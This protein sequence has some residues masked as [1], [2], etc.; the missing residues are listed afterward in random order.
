MMVASLLVAGAHFLFNY[1][2]AAIACEKGFAGLDIGG[3]GIVPLV[4]GCATAI[5]LIAVFA[6]LVG[7]LRRMGWRAPS[8]SDAAPAPVFLAWMTAAF[9]A[10]CIVA[11][12]WYSL[13]NF[14]V[15]VC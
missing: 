9:A 5:A 4:N 7:A 8:S 11:I 12:L 6:I 10:L 14:M 15:Q 2:F 3:Y 1:V 13:P